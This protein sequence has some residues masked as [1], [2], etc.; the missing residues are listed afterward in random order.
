MTDN[1]PRFHHQV[2]SNFFDWLCNFYDVST[3]SYFF[4]NSD[5]KFFDNELEFSVTSLHI[6]FFLFTV[7][8]NFSSISFL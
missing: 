1:T 8:D 3:V 7:H 4:L 2:V 6:V 5:F